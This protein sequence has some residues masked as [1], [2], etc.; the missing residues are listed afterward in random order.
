MDL[1]LPGED[2]ISILKNLKKNPRTEAIPVIITTAQNTEFDKVLGLDTGADDYIVKPF[3]MLELI[4]RIKA[5]L[6]RSA[7]KQPSGIENGDIKMSIENHQVSVG[8][9]PVELTLKEFQ[10]LELFL[11]HPGKVYTRDQ[12]TALVWGDYFLGETRTVDVHIGTLRAKLK[13]AGNSIKTV[14]G[15]GYKMDIM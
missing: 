15:V 6:R 2:G 10:L 1:M 5:V 12:I 14:R 7:P 13:E 9:D 11:K 8:G 4:S 3:G